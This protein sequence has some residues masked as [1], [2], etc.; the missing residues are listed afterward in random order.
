MNQKIYLRHGGRIHG[1]IERQQVLKLLE[2]GQVGSGDSWSQ[3][4]L[5]WQP[6]TSLYHADQNPQPQRP[7][8]GR[9]SP[10]P[11]PPQYASNE[12][13]PQYNRGNPDA[14]ETPVYTQSRLKSWLMPVGMAGIFLAV[15]VIVMSA[16]RPGR[17]DGNGDIPPAGGGGAPIPGGPNPIA[18]GGGDALLEARQILAKMGASTA[19]IVR[20]GDAEPVIGSGFLIRS[21]LLLTSAS[22]AG[23]DRGLL[24]AV[25]FPNG[26][27]DEKGPHQARIHHTDATNGIAILRLDAPQPPLLFSEATLLKSAEDLV[28]LASSGLEGPKKA[29]EILANPATYTTTT[30]RKNLEYHRLNGKTKPSFAGAPVLDRKG[31]VVGMVSDPVTAA[32]PLC[33]TSKQIL[34]LVKDV[35]LP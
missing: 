23:D 26:N 13:Q 34:K 35:P 4:G 18:P 10:Q 25:Y 7:V 5:E 22:V 17:E 11:A 16:L 9:P 30:T 32:D 27:G 29:S 33:L 6:I 2:M 19:L 20:M 12:D 8:W 15:M 24:I 14:W 1:P 3:D 21:N 28:I 31:K